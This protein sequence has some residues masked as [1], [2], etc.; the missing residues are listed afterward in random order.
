MKTLKG[1]AKTLLFLYAL[2]CVGLWFAQDKL[3]FNPTKLSEDFIFS[4]TNE[5][6]IEVD[7]GVFLNALWMREPNA[8]GVILYL[9]G[10]RGSN[11]RCQHQARNMANRG[12]D[13]LMVDYRGYGKSD[14]KIH[15]QGQLYADVQKVYDYLKK[16]YR[17]N[18]IVIVGYSLGSGMAS[19]LA[20][21]NSP[22][23][24]MLLAPY[25]S[26]Y[27]LKKRYIPIYI[28]NLFVKY[29]LD[30]EAH[31]AKVNCPVTIFHGTNDRVIPFAHG[32]QLANEYP[33]KVT[34]VTLNNE[35]HR[36]AIFNGQFRRTFGELVK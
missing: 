8:K 4:K 36:G 15:S 28:P 34:L 27:E 25:L 29:P 21:N 18:Q 20:A 11:R 9:H 23:Q 12:Y 35:S 19:Y 6:E 10:N 3:I 14:G 5:V 17:E 13:I 26:F 30:N 32:E 16:S 2:L 31:L 24:L 7:E 1:I 22:Q 33:E